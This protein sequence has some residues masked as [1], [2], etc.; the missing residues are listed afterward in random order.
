MK[1]KLMKNKKK[2][3]QK[4]KFTKGTCTRNYNIF[5][6]TVTYMTEISLIVTFIP[7]LHVNS[8]Q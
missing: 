4:K 7:L 8:L 3:F 1:M 2:Y 6:F 5:Y